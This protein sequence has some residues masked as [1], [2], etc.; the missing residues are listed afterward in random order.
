MTH[1]HNCSGRD[2][3]LIT[4]YDRILLLPL[5]RQGPNCILAAIDDDKVLQSPLEH[6]STACP[7]FQLEQKWPCSG[8][9]VLDITASPNAEMA[10]FLFSTS[11]CYGE[12]T[13]EICSPCC[14]TYFLTLEHVFC[15]P[16]AVVAVTLVAANIAHGRTPTA[17]FATAHSTTRRFSHSPG[18]GNILNDGLTRSL[19]LLLTVPKS[20]LC[21]T[22]LL[23]PRTL[24]LRRRSRPHFH[25]P[26]RTRRKRFKRQQGA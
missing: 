10:F 4:Y 22:L 2:G 19:S 1:R 9:R 20:N 8:P 18:D 25:C 24:S 3:A 21:H 17:L 12:F 26:P 16:T 14:Y 5:S 6:K 15:S 13:Q 11:R 23:G 7:A